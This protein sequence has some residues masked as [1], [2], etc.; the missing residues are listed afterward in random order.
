M[1]AVPEHCRWSGEGVRLEEVVTEL[2]RLHADLQTDVRGHALARTLNLI[3]APTSAPGA[4]AVEDTLERL[5]DHSPS[6][7]LVLRRQGSDRLDAE[8]AVECELP[9]APGRVGVFHDWVLLSAGDSR[10]EHAASLLAPLLLSDLPTVLWLPEPDSP[11]PDPRLL[12]R[13][14][15]LLADS[16]ADDGPAL[17]RLAQLTGEARVHD[18][19]WGRLQFWRAA[20]A[21]A[22]EP[23]ERRDL[24]PSVTQLEVR[25]GGDGMTA[26]LLLAGWV[27]ARTGWRPAALERSNGRAHGK[28]VRPDGGEVSVSLGRE[29]GAH[30]CGGVETLT[31]RAGSDE[32]CIERGAASNRFRDLF[33]EALQPLP[34]FARG[35]REALGAA[36]EMFA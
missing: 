7:T 23:P 21:S 15:Q 14:Q 34:S 1:K 25:Y 6:R 8:V 31:F 11:I 16:S 17:R 19:A 33:S 10:L 36:T 28:A 4:K 5:G 30:G 22:F 9:D 18:L 12:E 2:N 20:T 35:Y 13:A 24:L 29:D 32:V 27:T 26:A 3:V